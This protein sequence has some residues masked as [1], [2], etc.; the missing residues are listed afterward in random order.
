MLVRSSLSRRPVLTPSA[1][2]TVQVFRGPSGKDY[3]A[4]EFQ[5]FFVRRPESDSPDQPY[6][7]AALTSTATRVGQWVDARLSLRHELAQMKA[8][9]TPLTPAQ[10]AAIR[11]VLILDPAK[12]TAQDMI[13]TGI[14]TTARWTA[15]SEEDRRLVCSDEALTTWLNDYSS[16]KAAC[17]TRKTTEDFFEKLSAISHAPRARYLNVM[18]V[19]GCD[20][21]TAP[22]LRTMASRIS[23][24]PLLSTLIEEGSP[25]EPA[26]GGELM[27]RIA[28]LDTGGVRQY[29]EV[30]LAVMLQLSQQGAEMA[31][32]RSNMLG[33]KLGGKHDA[34]PM[35]IY[36]A[37]SW[38]GARSNPPPDFSCRPTPGYHEYG[39]LPL[40]VKAGAR[41]PSD[42]YRI[43]PRRLTGTILLTVLASLDTERVVELGR[44]N[45]RFMPPAR[46]RV[47]QSMAADIVNAIEAA[48]ARGHHVNAPVREGY[49]PIHLAAL[50]YSPR[51]EV[52]RLLH[53]KGADVNALAPWGDGRNYA[54]PLTWAVIGTSV[55]RH[56]GTLAALLD[57]GA[58]PNLLDREG[59]SVFD[60]L[61]EFSLALSLNIAELLLN[62]GARLT[63]LR[64][65]CSHHQRRR[66]IAVRQWC[67]TARE[68]GRA[69]L[70]EKLEL[71]DVSLTGA[72]PIRR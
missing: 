47:H 52:I 50:A 69:D 18:R 13:D 59:L 71:H 64:S 7:R 38:Y 9:V 24:L 19:V 23:T 15:Y 57:C 68:M 31:E 12:R 51:G 34:L 36:C 66:R 6:F 63:D 16:A 70:I 61:V 65:D 58:D 5:E 10:Q 29:F 60:R 20:L 28:L 22:L 44:G 46:H 14:V 43:G 67:R 2:E 11:A 49:R 3:A 54:V 45:T 4:M 40:L 21:R 56:T 39:V 26:T 35:A 8:G 37:A 17:L 55:T 53:A 30:K 27:Y 48:C 1:V 62:R 41:M 32:D 25:I 42:E 72:L 33:S